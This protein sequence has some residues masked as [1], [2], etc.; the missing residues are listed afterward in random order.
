M[1]STV[2]AEGRREH[3]ADVI[4]YYRET[5]YDYRCFWT[6]AQSAALHM[7]YWD[8][9]VRSHSDSLLAINR[10]IADRARV[11]RGDVVLDAGCGVGGSA[12][13]LAQHRGARVA[14][15]TIVPDQVAEA[16]RRA[17]ER[18]VADRVA[19]HEMDFV[20][21]DFEDESF[22]VVWAQESLTHEPRKQDFLREAHRLLKPGGR[23]VVEDTFIHDGAIPRRDRRK[24]AAILRG[25]A[26]A[27]LCTV[28]AFEAWARELGFGRLDFHDINRYLLPSARRLRRM[29][30]PLYPL[31]YLQYALRLRTRAQ[32]LHTVAAWH[33]VKAMETHLVFYGIFTAEKAG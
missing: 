7:G 29:I 11:G 24:I 15:I 23:L 17:V 28:P 4:R 26:S 21:T 32:H 8:D 33:I 10:L 14:G 30:V 31:E 16:T 6:D 13:W 27:D 22:D 3:L 9:G 5:W 1:R 12:V 2:A 25:W 18:G 20:A 19:F